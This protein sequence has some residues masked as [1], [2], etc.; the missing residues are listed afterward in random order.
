MNYFKQIIY[1]MKHQRMMTWVSVS[2]TALSIFLV[3]AFFITDNF[4]SVDVAPETSRSRVLLGEGVH[5]KEGDRYDSSGMSITLKLAEKIYTGLD[6]I[7]RISFVRGDK[8]AEQLSVSGSEPFVADGR[9]VDAEFWKIF[10]FKFI[11]GKPFTDSKAAAAERA[12]VLTRSAARRL[13]NEDKVA[14]RDIEIRMIPFH[15]VGVV[16]DVSPLL[17]NTYGYYFTALDK[18]QFRSTESDDAIFGSLKVILK[19]K[20][21]VDADYIKEQVKNR[22]DRF[23]AELKQNG[24]ELIYHDQPYTGEELT[25][26]FGSNNSPDIKSHKRQ[27]WII[28]ALLLLLPAINLSSMTRSR[29]RHRVSEIGVRRAFGAK[30]VDII[31]QLLGENLLI[32]CMGGIIGFLFCILFLYLASHLFFEMG[33]SFESSLEVL[34]VRPDFSMLFRWQNFLIAFIVCFILNIVSATVP[35]WR[36]SRRNPA[37]AISGTH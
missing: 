2:G 19:M 13:F 7:E 30:K 18:E 36:A 1:E 31:G 24:K 27:Q 17:D 25:L 15:V 35:A 10:D 34:N 9:K 6:G 32:T 28:Y 4:S 33:G 26:F 29:L 37:E 8:S 12:V 16:E 14:G 5:I 3:M 20:D 22:Y 11:D 21:G 23:G